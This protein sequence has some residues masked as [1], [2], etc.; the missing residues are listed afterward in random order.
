MGRIFRLFKISYIIMGYIAW[1]TL[2][3][4]HYVRSSINPAAKLCNTLERLGT[5][6]IKLGQALSLRQELLPPDYIAALQNLQDNVSTFSSDFAIKEIEQSFGAPINKLFSQFEH[7]PIAAASIAQ[8]HCAVLFDGLEVI[9]KVRRPDIKK[10]IIWDIQILRMVIPLI[11]L[12]LPRFRKYHPAKIV[13]ELETNLLKELDFRLESR[14]IRR[15]AFAFKDSE[16]VYVPPVIDELCA[17]RVLTQIRSYGLRVDDPAIGGR[18]VKLAQIITD[19][20]VQQF[21]VMGLFHGD[22]HPG[23]LFV[24]DDDRICFHDFGLVGYLDHDT[25]RNLAAFMQAFIDHDAEWMT[26]ACLDLGILGGEIDR[27]NFLRSLEELVEEYAHL[28]LKDYSL[29]EVIMRIA[30]MGRDSD[31]SIP[32]NLLIFSR[33]LSLLESVIRDLDKEFNLEERLLQHAE[34][35]LKTGSIKGLSE[36]KIARL[37]Y[38]IA[39]AVQDLPLALGSTLRRMRNEGPDWPIPRKE[40]ADLKRN[41][42]RGTNRL[43]LSLVTL[44]LYIASSLL[45]QHSIGPRVGN[46]PVLAVIG[47]A[48]ALW[49]TL[50][51]VFAINRSGEL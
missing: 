17:E 34:T 22:P 48:L 12:F 36:A 11:T 28:P 39:L 30:R 31:I 38:E 18:G 37:K 6:F 42:N 5:S 29:A 4:F 26:D 44:G 27:R 51:L 19:A 21:F 1:Y 46:V 50:R 15:F 3:H 43:V 13:S 14:N 49:F 45:M 40:I 35:L 47:Y 9:V 2:V 8:V 32:N 33:T 41:I 7:Q 23:N 16:N 10:Q 25:R 20:Y 24:T